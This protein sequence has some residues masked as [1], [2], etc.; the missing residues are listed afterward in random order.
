MLQLTIVLIPVMFLLPGVLPVAIVIVVG[1][2]IVVVVPTIMVMMVATVIL[3]VSMVTIIVTPVSLRIV[4]GGVSRTAVPG[5]LLV[6]GWPAP[7]PLVVG[8]PVTVIWAGHIVQCRSHIVMGSIPARVEVRQWSGF[9]ETLHTLVC[10][11]PCIAHLCW[12]SKIS[13]RVGGLSARW[14]GVEGLQCWRLQG[15]PSTSLSGN[16]SLIHHPSG[17]SL[18][19]LKP[20]GR[21][22]CSHLLVQGMVAEGGESSWLYLS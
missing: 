6:V 18:R 4:T 1:R 8:V 3:M 2:I 19:T 5:P 12:S 10:P 20:M 14:L 21:Q 16:P 17:R 13:G 7:L 22:W 11:L 15:K 9:S